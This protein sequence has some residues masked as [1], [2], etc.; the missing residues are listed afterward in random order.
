MNASVEFSSLG[1]PAPRTGRQRVPAFVTQRG[2]AIAGELGD[3]RETIYAQ[4]QQVA[5]R[6]LA[7]FNP[8]ANISP[9]DLTD[10]VLSAKSLCQQA[11]LD[12]RF[13]EPPASLYRDAHFDNSALTWLDGTTS[14]HQHGFSGAFHV[15]AGGSIHARYSFKPD[16]LI[17]H[18]QR[19]A[20]GQLERIDF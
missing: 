18:G 3:T 16:R 17:A 6:N 9:D 20:I 1:R 2:D 4:L 14:I 8:A 13:A 19:A 7:H 5:A 10:Y 12:A 11:D 15:P